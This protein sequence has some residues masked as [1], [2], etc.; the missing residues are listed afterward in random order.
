[1]KTVLCVTGKIGAGKSTVVKHL[2]KHSAAHVFDCDKIVT[3][4]YDDPHVKQDLIDRFKT[5]SKEAI[6][7]LLVECQSTW[8][9]QQLNQVFNR[10]I[11][12]AFALW[13]KDKHGLLIL[14]APLVFETGTLVL[15]SDFILQI[16]STHSNRFDRIIERSPKT[17]DV[18]NILDASQKSDDCREKHANN[19]VHN[20]GT[21]KELTEAVD[22][23][24][25]PLLPSVAVYAGSFD[26]ITKG[27]V[28]IAEKAA[29]MFDILYVAVGTNPEKHHTLNSQVRMDLISEELSHIPNVSVVCYGDLLISAARRLNCSHII[30]GI[31]NQADAI[32]EMSMHGIHFHADPSIQTIFIPADPTLSFVSS[33]AAKVLM[34][35]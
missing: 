28:N 32:S 21:I 33:S 16:S 19:H 30:R 35:S 12:D 8:T 3:A 22:K 7:D 4:L 5:N 18:F 17:A 6:R 29:K 27:H 9:V 31:R 20:N 11:H 2:A 13:A 10:R 24:V 34:D 26:P 14:D 25:Y 1:M 23:I 15:V